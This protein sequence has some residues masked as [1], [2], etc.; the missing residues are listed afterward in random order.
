M[1]YFNEVSTKTPTHTHKKQQQMH[2]RHC[3]PM[4]VKNAKIYF[5]FQ[6]KLLPE[7][8]LKIRIKKGRKNK[9]L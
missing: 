6:Q 3:M 1:K 7:E 5:C 2:T 9:N 4:I 8:E